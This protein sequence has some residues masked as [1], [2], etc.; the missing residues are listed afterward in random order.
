MAAS[1]L[2]GGGP[3]EESSHFPGEPVHLLSEIPVAAKLGLAMGPEQPNSS[4][5]MARQGDC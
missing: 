4:I 5:N 1:A 3:S 2:G